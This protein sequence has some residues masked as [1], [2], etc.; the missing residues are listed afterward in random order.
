MLKEGI[1]LLHIACV[2]I[3]KKSGRYV[4]TRLPV[5]R[6]NQRPCPVVRSVPVTPFTASGENCPSGRF[7]PGVIED[8]KG[9]PEV[10]TGIK[11][12]RDFVRTVVPKEVCSRR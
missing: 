10:D 6:S 12:R 5:F 3:S 11:H 4:S 1:T 8:T 7:T 2:D 9:S